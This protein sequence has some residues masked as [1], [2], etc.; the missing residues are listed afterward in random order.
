MVSD[1]SLYRK[2]LLSIHQSL[3]KLYNYLINKRV[4]RLL[5]EQD[6]I[7]TKKLGLG[8]RGTTGEEESEYGE[9]V[10]PSHVC[11]GIK[12][13]PKTHLHRTLHETKTK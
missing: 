8:G 9:G 11:M 2:S 5:V 1:V 10:D 4:G 3:L 12:C 7:G 6:F 13:S